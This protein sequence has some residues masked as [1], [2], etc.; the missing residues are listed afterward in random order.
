[1][2]HRNYWHIL[3]FQL[4]LICDQAIA[5]NV[6]EDGLQVEFIQKLSLSE[7]TGLWI[8]TEEATFGFIGIEKA[9]NIE[10]S[11]LWRF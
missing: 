4:K 5:F 8:Q 1:M 10:N 3:F 6:S 2:D 11:R 9:V 7:Y